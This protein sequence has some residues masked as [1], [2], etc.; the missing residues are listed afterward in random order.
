MA[1]E[2]NAQDE[3][4]TRLKEEGDHSAVQGASDQNPAAESQ[5]G[6]N[7]DTEMETLRRAAGGDLSRFTD[8]QIEA[9]KRF[10]FSPRPGSDNRG[11]E[12]VPDPLSFLRSVRKGVEE[13]KAAE[14]RQKKKQKAK[15][16]SDNEEEKDGGEKKSESDGECSQTEED[17]QTTMGPQPKAGPNPDDNDLLVTQDDLDEANLMTGNIAAIDAFSLMWKD[18][19]PPPLM[20]PPSRSAEQ[21]VNVWMRVIE[22]GTAMKKMIKVVKRAPLSPEEQ[23]KNEAIK[24][25]D[26]KLVRTSVTGEPIIDAKVL[27]RVYGTLV[28]KWYPRTIKDFDPVPAPP[29]PEGVDI[30]DPEFNPTRYAAC[31]MGTN[32][33]GTIFIDSPHEEVDYMLGHAQAARGLEVAI[34]TM[35]VGETVLVRTTTGSCYSSARRPADVPPDAVLEFLFTLVRVEKEKNL[36]EMTFEEKMDF[37]AQRRE[38]AKK[39]FAQ[40]RPRSA[41]RQYDKALTVL[42]D[43]EV[44]KKVHLDRLKE[45]AVLLV[46]QALCANKYGDYVTAIELAS[47]VIDGMS[48]ARNVKARYQRAMAYKARQD[49]DNA[50]RDL[51]IIIDVLEQELQRLPTAADGEKQVPPA[52]SKEYK[53]DDD[54]TEDLAKLRTQKE[55]LLKR[56]RAEL[57][58]VESRIAAE[59]KQ[60]A[61]AFKSANLAKKAE[62]SL[63]NQDGG[64]Y[65]DR[66][67]I[68]L[69]QQLKEQ[70]RKVVGS[71]ESKGTFWEGV[72]TLAQFAGHVIWNGVKRM[73][74]NCL[75]RT[76]SWWSKDAGKTKSQ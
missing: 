58:I 8:A 48:D 68:P 71:E 62:V 49:W 18:A 33:E 36:H 22:E 25:L 21:P 3:L 46:N 10:A 34:A 38:I 72:S 12:S 26:E 45:V 63:F 30:N 13:D 54:S 14:R 6:S 1:S 60:S 64:L 55:A 9:L 19:L 11:D 43:E 41:A 15:Q 67:V 24:R 76:K 42:D 47:K 27:H 39:L 73:T 40:G 44:V 4:D 75:R 70:R 53:A 66:P 37:V 57:K 29:L 52:E 20:G 17:E 59:L 32:P 5:T 50:A 61:T 35:C 28:A 31:Y 65:A 16:G 7:E 2:D 23:K 74:G 51:R 56:T 69:E